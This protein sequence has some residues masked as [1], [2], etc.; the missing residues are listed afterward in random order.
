MRQSLRIFRKDVRNLWPRIAVVVALEVALS[1]VRYVGTPWG[2]VVLLLST[3][4]AAA[5]AY[6][7]QAVFHQEAVPGHR[8]Y[9]LTRPFSP[10][11]L[12]GA[13]AMFALAFLCVPVLTIHTASLALHT[14]SPLNYL[15][16]MVSSQFFFAARLILPMAAVAAITPNLVEFTW[17]ILAAFMGYVMLT[18]S[19]FWFAW[20]DFNWGGVEWVRTTF[21]AMVGVAVCLIAVR[22]QYMRRETKI[23]RAILVAALALESATTW[24][25]GWHAAFALQ[26]RLR[27]RVSDGVVRV[28]FDPERD[29]HTRPSGSASWPGQKAVGIYIPVRVTGIPSGGA[30]YADRAN[31]A[32]DTA[33]GSQWNTGW[34]SLNGLTQVFGIPSSEIPHIIGG[35]KKLLPA[36]GE[37]WLYANVKPALS[38]E[39]D[40]AHRRIRA[41]LA[42]TLLS[43]E[44]LTTL[45]MRSGPQAAPDDGRCWVFQSGGVGVGCTWA[46]QMP[47][48]GE[49]RFYGPQGDPYILMFQPGSYGPFS[50]DGPWSWSGHSLGTASYRLNPVPVRA[51]LVTR[52]AVA[53]FEREVEIPALGEWAKR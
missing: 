51:E 38:Y 35:D 13:K 25:P 52:R 8:Q 26:S 27:E 36:D 2:G 5:S 41:R 39:P 47:V 53:H 28:T 37:Y 33:D 17:T 44:R 22:L 40:F 10:G 20:G 1:W 32:I 46:G 50:V 49:A 9:W 16:D 11:R 15:P 4:G 34:D 18:M 43:A 14:Q 24:M 30:L 21:L 12:L 29:P 48:H 45:S 19:W 42:L 3:I 23:A 7:V 6:L 31:V